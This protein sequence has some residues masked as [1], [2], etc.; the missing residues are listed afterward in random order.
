MYSNL[1]TFIVAICFFSLGCS[2]VYRSSEWKEVE[3][4]EVKIAD[5]QVKHKQNKVNFSLDELIQEALINNSE[6]KG[7]FLA[8]KSD[9]LKTVSAGT[10]PEP[11]FS[12]SNYIEAVETRVGPQEQSF[13][14][15]QQFPFFGKRSKREQR[16]MTKAL[17]TKER[18][19]ASK[20]KLIYDVKEAYYE[21]VYLKQMVKITDTNE[22][23]LN[24]FEKIVQTGYRSGKAANENLLK[25]QVSLALLAD[26]KTALEDMAKASLVRIK[27]L[28]GLSVESD[29]KP[30]L[31]YELF[32]IEASKFDIGTFT[33]DMLKSNPVLKEVL[34]RLD[35]A[36]HSVSLAKLKFFPDVT[37]GGTY[38]ETAES[39]F[40]VAE[41]GKDPVIV[42]AKVNLP[43]WYSSLNSS[44]LAAKSYFDSQKN[45]LADMEAKL[46]AE[47]A[48]V[49][50][51]VK[52][53]HRKINLYG[54]GLIPKANQI[55]KTTEASYKSGEVDFLSLIDAQRSILDMELKFAKAK[56][57]Y[58]KQ[59][60]KLEQLTGSKV[61]QS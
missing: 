52:D 55:L 41:S 45:L 15:T 17:Q 60:A 43:I 48:L 31:S 33:Q 6:L 8:W 14:L 12:Y 19:N 9:L 59:M 7:L 30:D 57:D 46:Q 34:Y 50:Y 24:H 23:L 16:A 40:D 38:I 44:L 51:K 56:A 42:M 58:S 4:T 21:Y 1:K 22:K 10:L 36:R 3:A 54:N 26:E 18:Y 29:L 39:Q 5:A 35:E 32:T 37:V 27:A 53:A 20:L 61:R 13:Q 28:V 47:L 49:F 2:S 11:F 25:A